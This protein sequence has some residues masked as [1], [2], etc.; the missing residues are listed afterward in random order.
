M[1]WPSDETRTPE[2]VSVKRVGPAA[3]TSRPRARITTTDGAIFSNTSRA[4][5][6]A[7]TPS[8]ARTARAIATVID[9]FMN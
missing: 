9:A 4:V 1:T 8:P 3:V 6:A 2:P 5:W 7:A